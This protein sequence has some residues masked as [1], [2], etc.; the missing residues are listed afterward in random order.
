M[1]QQKQREVP[2]EN[3]ASPTA[4][5]QAH[6]NAAFGTSIPQGFEGRYSDMENTVKVTVD[7]L[8]E[9]VPEE[10][11]PLPPP[12]GPQLCTLPS[13]ARRTLCSGS[14]LKPRLHLVIALV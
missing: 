7:L 13:G 11:L 8:T 6:S 14:W 4:H 12:V 10:A 9:L 1:G 5:S 3:P 2:R